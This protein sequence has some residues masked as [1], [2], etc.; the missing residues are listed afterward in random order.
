MGELPCYIYFKRQL[1]FTVCLKHRRFRF[2]LR[3]NS[4]LPLV[5]LD[6]IRSLIYESRNLNRELPVVT[7][8]L[9]T[10]FNL[11]YKDP[12]G[13]LVSQNVRYETAEIL[14]FLFFLV[15]PTRRTSEDLR[16]LVGG[17]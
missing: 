2:I 5:S 4:R 10:H 7:R 17:D 3:F 11:I 12:H 1:N 9:Y 15:R 13:I 14:Y 16:D 6:I 8:F